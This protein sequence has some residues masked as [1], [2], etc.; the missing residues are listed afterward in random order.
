MT[1]LREQYLA[2]VTGR[3]RSSRSASPYITSDVARPLTKLTAGL[4]KQFSVPSWSFGYSSA[5]LD[6]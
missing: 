4:Q 6:S 2:G 5:C 3:R 1:S